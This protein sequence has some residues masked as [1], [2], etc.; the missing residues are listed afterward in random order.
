[1]AAAPATIAATSTPTH[2]SGKSA[3]GAQQSR[4]LVDV[5]GKCERTEAFVVTI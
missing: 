2:A 4:R 1:M 5:V 3:A